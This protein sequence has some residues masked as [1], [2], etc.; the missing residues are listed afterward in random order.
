MAI[1]NQ[2]ILNGQIKKIK[3]IQQVINEEKEI[4]QISIALF[5]IRRPQAAVGNKN[6]E[7][8]TPA[9]YFL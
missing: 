8:K 9:Q 6:G 7:I 4:I 3:K 1:Q 2:I 5:V